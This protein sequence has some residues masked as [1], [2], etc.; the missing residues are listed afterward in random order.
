MR[1]HGA[2]RRLPGDL[3]DLLQ[4]GLVRRGLRH[5]EA[6]EEDEHGVDGG[7]TVVPSQSRVPSRI[8]RLRAPVRAPLNWIGLLVT[9][10]FREYMVLF[11]LLVG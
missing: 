3:S 9:R 8:S 5:E 11:L 1:L 6:E 2:G 4:H 10:F 7:D